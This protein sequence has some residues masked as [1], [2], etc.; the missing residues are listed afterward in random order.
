M[1]D[2]FGEVKTAE[3][4]GAELLALETHLRP[5]GLSVAGLL[6]HYGRAMFGAPPQ[7]PRDPPPA[8]PPEIEELP[9][10]APDDS[11]RRG[12]R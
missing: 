6:E 2:T 8:G 12:R 7:A 3:R 9:E 11:H 10:E 4:M 1:A 5:H